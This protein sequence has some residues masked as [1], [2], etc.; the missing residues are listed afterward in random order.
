MVEII[1]AS[2]AVTAAIAFLGAIVYAN[3]I[4]GPR[5]DREYRERQ[6]KVVS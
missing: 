3:F 6:Q 1:V 2:I 4:W 5:Q